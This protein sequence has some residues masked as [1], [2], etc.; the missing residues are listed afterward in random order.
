M[1]STSIE[2]TDMTWNP[3]RGCSPVSPGCKN[4]YAEAFAA[5][6]LPSSRSP[7]TGEAFAIIRSD[8]PHWTGRVELIE[9][10]LLE[11]LHWKKL[12]RVFVNSMSDLFHENLP[13]EAIDRVFA[14]MA[15]TPHI[16]YQVLTKRA[17]RMREY[18][19][20]RLRDINWR[21][22]MRRE[23]N[24]AVAAIRMHWPLPNVWLGVSVEDQQRADERIPQL[25]RTPAAKR[26]VSYEPALAAVDFMKWLPRIND[27]TERGLRISSG[28]SR[29]SS[30]LGGWDDL[31]NSESALEPMGE[32][33]DCSAVQAETRRTRLREISRDSSH[34]RRQ[35][36]L[37]ASPSS[38]LSA[39][40]GTDSRRPDSEPR[41]WKEEAQSPGQSH[42]GDGFRTTDSR[43]AGIGDP[44]GGE[45]MGHQESA[46]YT[47]DRASSGD[48][49]AP[50]FGGKTADDRG[51]LQRNGSDCFE[52]SEGGPAISWLIIGGESGPGARPFNLDWLR[53]TIQQFKEAG[54]PLFVK[55]MGARPVSDNPEDLVWI[56]QLD[57]KGGNWDVWPEWA[58]VREF[59]K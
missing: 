34:D 59:P 20:H 33:R 7:I 56:T 50:S 12:R 4:C 31:E 52:D 8:G 37:R 25:L 48:S 41:G 44:P 22:I 14:V 55:Q 57:S 26:F 23:H 10:K 38:G 29:R 9:S 28:H 24:E 53:S 15:L 43:R 49:A 17:E 40:Q 32:S 2:W 51:G 35:A 58:R 5:R 3:T 46:Q 16:T 13:D 45:S 1:S 47:D 42:A 36:S 21:T 11:P 27:G 6:N 30:N 39:L 54:V 19:T 18:L